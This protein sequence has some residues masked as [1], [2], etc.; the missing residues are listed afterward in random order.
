MEMKLF[1]LYTLTKDFYDKYQAK[2]SLSD[3]KGGRPVCCIIKDDTYENLYYVIPMHS[4]LEGEEDNDGSLNTIKRFEQAHKRCDLVHAAKL[5]DGITSVF[6]I[7]FLHPV[8]SKYVQ[9]EYLQ[10]NV[11]FEIKNTNLQNDL[12]EKAKR[13][14]ELRKSALIKIKKNNI[15]FESMGFAQQTAY[16][17]DELQN[18]LM[19]EL[20]EA[21]TANEASDSSE[22]NETK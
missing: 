22:T 15:K 14:L 20:N 7:G 2:Y 6:K 10:N 11:A 19:Q 16:L 4:V 1:F 5:I 18:E 17:M 3:N 8:I 9:G 21:S 13:I 12:S